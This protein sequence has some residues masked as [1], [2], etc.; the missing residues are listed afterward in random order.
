MAV[1]PTWLLVLAAACAEP[2][3]DPAPRA[4]GTPAEAAGRVAPAQP[5]AIAPSPQYGAP[6]GPVPTPVV[7][8]APVALARGGHSFS[9]VSVAVSEDGTAAFTADARHHGRL[10]PAL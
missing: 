9:I 6:I 10:W 2:A 3:P 5:R 8:A 4:G 1:R 7:P